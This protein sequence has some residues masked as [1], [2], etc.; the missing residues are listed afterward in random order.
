MEA[1]I[2]EV[3]AFASTFVP[4]GWMLCNGAKLNVQDYPVL[5]TVLGYTYG[6]GQAT[7]ALPDL[8]GCAVIGAI[9]STDK[10]PGYPPGERVGDAAVTL[11]SVPAHSHTLTGLYARSQPYPGLTAT[12]APD[13]L[14]A[15]PTRPNL[16]DPAKPATLAY[17]FAA[18]ASVSDG[19]VFAA[20]TLSPSG[21]TALPH[22]N[23]QPYLPLLYCICV[24]GTYPTPGPVAGE[25]EREEPIIAESE[26]VGAR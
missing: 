24:E 20:A 22:E 21:G 7:F 12:P 15:R 2:G 5:Y 14:L 1:Y 25:A 26:A 10:T 18:P 17:A 19:D 9:A 13:T 6:G 11:T 8:M 4:R 16:Q 23:R 3:R